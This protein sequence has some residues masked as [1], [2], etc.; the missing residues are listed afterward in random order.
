MRDLPAT[1]QSL[2]GRLGGDDDAWPEF[3]LIY[4]RAIR[5]YCRRR[6]LQ[7]AD[8]EDVTQ[9]VLAAV[10]RRLDR[11]WEP[12]PGVG[13]F[14]GW[15]QRVTCNRV[16]ARRQAIARRRAMDG[17]DAQLQLAAV[18][19]PDPAAESNALWTEFR[20]SLLQRAAE[21]VEPQVRPASWR[22]FWLTAV[23][24]RSGEQVAAELGMTVGS[25]YTAKCRVLARIRHVAERFDDDGTQLRAEELSNGTRQPR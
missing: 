12:D 25:V 6:G 13:R 5:S 17:S 16:A 8:A 14:R 21:L 18:P 7:E 10:H 9:E 23:E 19:A 4:Q 24:G 20:H 3:L 1:R 15:L 2:L 22:A 11:A